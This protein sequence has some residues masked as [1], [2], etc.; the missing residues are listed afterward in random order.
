MNKR[1]SKGISKY[2]K[3][4]KSDV[5]PIKLGNENKTGKCGMCGTRVKKLYHH[6]IGQIDFM[7]CENCKA[8]IDI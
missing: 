3:L 4:L 1:E 6:K 7:I 2:L 8:L 5:P